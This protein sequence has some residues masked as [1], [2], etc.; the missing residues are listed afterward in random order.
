MNTPTNLPRT[1]KALNARFARDGLPV[2]LVRG[3]GYLYFV[4]EDGNP[5]HFDTRSIYVARFAHQSPETWYSDAVA[6]VRDRRAELGRIVELKAEASRPGNFARRAVV[7]VTAL[8]EVSARYFPKYCE[9]DQFEYFHNG[10]R[11]DEARAAELAA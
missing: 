7:Y 4:F 2:E 10:V 6:F 5:N 3:V 1:L 11:I 8:D 9:G